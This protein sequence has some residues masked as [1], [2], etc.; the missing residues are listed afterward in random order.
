MGE[1]KLSRE[2][3]DALWGAYLVFA[4]QLRE[5]DR[6][7]RGGTTLGEAMQ[8]GAFAYAAIQVLN[9]PAYITKQVTNHLNWWLGERDVW[10][11]RRSEFLIN[12]RSPP[13]VAVLGK[14]SMDGE[15]YPGPEE[16]GLGAA[17]APSMTEA[18]AE[19][20]IKALEEL[21]ALCLDLADAFEKRLED[22]GGI[23]RVQ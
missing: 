16:V 14:K 15:P 19:H 17:R 21:A 1:E 22:E 20:R 13:G 2:E 11:A 4:R 12:R 9:D 8:S 18:K 5:K 7:G 10:G 3:F 23:R 6:H